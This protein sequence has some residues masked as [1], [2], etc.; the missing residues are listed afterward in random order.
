MSRFLSPHLPLPLLLL[1][2][3]L[4]LVLHHR[5]AACANPLPPPHADQLAVIRKNEQLLAKLRAKAAHHANH[6][7]SAY[8][9][10]MMRLEAIIHKMHAVIWRNSLT[11]DQSPPTR[12]ADMD[13]H[14]ADAPYIHVRR[15]A[16][17]QIDALFELK[18]ILIHHLHLDS[19]L[20]VEEH[21]KLNNRILQIMDLIAAEKKILRNEITAL[22]NQLD[23]YDSASSPVRAIVDQL[24]ARLHA[25]D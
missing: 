7:L 23:A 5:H 24:V 8:G 10:K 21:A 9:N 22:T 3:L 13:A 4:L 12:N 2:L 15:K 1:P 18:Q 19:S 11:H 16:V 6:D 25:D 14:P 17:A 20:T